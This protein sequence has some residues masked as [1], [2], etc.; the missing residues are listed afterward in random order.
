L[1]WKVFFLF[2]ATIELD[3][4]YDCE[5]CKKKSKATKKLSLT[6]TP[7]YL[8]IALKKFTQSGKKI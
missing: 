3:D 5:K 4:L 8:M 2:Y 6:T 7:N 1:R